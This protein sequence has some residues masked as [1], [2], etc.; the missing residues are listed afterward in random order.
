MNPLPPLA[1]PLLRQLKAKAQLLEPTLHVG[2]SGLAP[3]F[4]KSLAD[5]LERKELV[6]VKF[7]AFKDQKG[8][9]VKELAAVSESHLV[10]RVGNVAVLYRRH[11]EPGRRRFE[12]GDE[13]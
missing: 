7:V 5:E 2:K 12:S 11:A 8:E 6:K 3:G 10:M 13:T 4:L 1:G 9:L